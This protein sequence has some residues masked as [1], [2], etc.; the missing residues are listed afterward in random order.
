MNPATPEKRKSDNLCKLLAETY[1]AQFAAWLFG[2]KSGITVDKSEL[3][4]EPIRADS[5]IFSH[6]ASETLHI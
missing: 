5:V 2:V 4:R 6:D 1:P 3:S